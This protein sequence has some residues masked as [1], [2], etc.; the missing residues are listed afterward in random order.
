MELALHSAKHG[1]KTT[2]VNTEFNHQ[3]VVSA[4]SDTESLGMVNLVSGQRTP[5][6]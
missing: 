1:I 6:A 2:F 3:R 5:T 4:L